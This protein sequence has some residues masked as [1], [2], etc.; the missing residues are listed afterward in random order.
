MKKEKIHTFEDLEVYK[1]AREFSRMISKL[2]KKLPREEDYNL[3]HQMRRAKLSTTN[4][5]AEGY[6]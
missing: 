2:I 4:N 3:K 1:M 6:G 5:I